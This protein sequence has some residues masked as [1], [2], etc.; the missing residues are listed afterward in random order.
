MKD[1]KLFELETNECKSINGGTFAWDAGWFIGNTIAGNFLS[2][3]GTA[4]ALLDY[5]LHYN[6]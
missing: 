4:E 5:A 3:S 2:F 1:N 6:E